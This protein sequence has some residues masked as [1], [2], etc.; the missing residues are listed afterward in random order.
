M[1]DVEVID[2]AEYAAFAAS[3]KK[4]RDAGIESPGDNVVHWSIRLEGPQCPNCNYA[5]GLAR[6]HVRSVWMQILGD[7]N[8]DIQSPQFYG[9][10]QSANFSPTDGLGV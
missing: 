5:S 2:D 6:L 1:Y 7:K 8:V 4:A 3:F 9:D 10:G